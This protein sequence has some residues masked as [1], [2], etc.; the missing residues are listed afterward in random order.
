MV[1][2][3]RSLPRITT[4]VFRFTPQRMPKPGVLVSKYLGLLSLPFKERTLI[5]VRCNFKSVSVLS[6]EWSEQPR[7]LVMQHESVQ[8]R[9]RKT[10]KKLGDGMRRCGAGLN[11][12]GKLP[13][14]H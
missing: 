12:L 6:L 1:T 14:Y 4:Q 7:F 10:F 2:S 3:S 8:H 11:L 5:S 9:L 13:F